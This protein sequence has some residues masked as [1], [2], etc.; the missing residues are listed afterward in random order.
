MYV[1]ALYQSTGPWPVVAAIVPVVVVLFIAF[2]VLYCRKRKKPN[3]DDVEGKS[4]GLPLE[5]SFVAICSSY[6][7]NYQAMNISIACLLVYSRTL[8]VRTLLMSNTWLGSTRI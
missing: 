7:Y 2:A 1:C 4:Q 3:T 8:L 5:Y 6:E